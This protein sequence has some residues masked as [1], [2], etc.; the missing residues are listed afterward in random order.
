ME[1]IHPDLYAHHT[2]TLVRTSHQNA[3]TIQTRSC[4]IKQPYKQ[5]V[6]ILFPYNMTKPVFLKHANEELCKKNIIYSLSHG[7]KKNQT[8]ITF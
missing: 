8:Y 1:E 2:Y 7:H 3:Q 5:Y 6:H 4:N